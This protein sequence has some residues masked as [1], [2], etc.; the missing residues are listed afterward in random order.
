VLARER[1]GETRLPESLRVAIDPLNLAALRFWHR[2][3]FAR[4]EKIV[5]REPG[6]TL[7]ELVSHLDCRSGG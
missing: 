4:I 6:Y 2:L 5:T 1:A 3:G 7:L